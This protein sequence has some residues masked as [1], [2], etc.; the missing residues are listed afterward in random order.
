MV[1]WL[2]VLVASLVLP[3][4]GS[5][6]GWDFGPAMETPGGRVMHFTD[7]G[8]LA[9][10]DVPELYD[11]AAEDAAVYLWKYGLEPDQVAAALSTYRVAVE[12]HFLFPTNSSGTG[13]AAGAISVETRTLIVALYTRQRNATGPEWTRHYW[14]STG[15]TH[16]GLIPR[17]C[18]ALAH[19]LGHHFFGSRFEHGWIPPV[20]NGRA[21]AS[22]EVP[23]WTGFCSFEE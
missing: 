11:G 20:L 19:E 10:Y 14:P 6:G 13:Y 21:L 22:N 1:R 18:P 15:E 9:L 3:A 8:S 2:T 23:D 17:A 7:R 16:S 12:D 4:C 5:G